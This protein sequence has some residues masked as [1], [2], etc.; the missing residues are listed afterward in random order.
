MT[1]LKQGAIC[2]SCE[3]GKLGLTKKD[4]SFEYKG[5]FKK[6]LNEKVYICDL[7]KFELVA[8]L[9]NRRIEKILT[10]FRR[11]I[12]SL[13]QCDDL[14]RIRKNLGLNKKQMAK[15]LAVNE[16]TIGRY[17]T[18]K[19]TQ[20]EHMDKLYRVLRDYPFTARAINPDV[21]IARQTSINDS[22]DYQPKLRNKYV[23]SADGY[24]HNQREPIYA[25][26]C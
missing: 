8:E 19:V 15:L 25:E 26:R 17:E 2:P 4:L 14:I 18:G 16:K 9:D 6:L 3:K 24:S 23:F 7:C 11:N 10:D 20:S 1:I 21:V 13:L 5:R 22:L 12:D